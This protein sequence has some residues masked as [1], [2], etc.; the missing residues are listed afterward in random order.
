MEKRK[1]KRFIEQDDVLIRD[2]GLVLDAA[3][4]GVIYGFTR[5]ISLSGTRIVSDQVF[6]VGCHWRMLIDLKRSDELLRVDGRVIWVKKGK[7]AQRFHIG[8][9]F[10]HSYPHTTR[11]LIKH[12]Y[13][14]QGEV[15]APVS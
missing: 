4:D 9:E 8:V 2:E 10:L 13:G 3:T 1:E 15:P 14:R 12:L 7:N 6:P 5:D 11:L